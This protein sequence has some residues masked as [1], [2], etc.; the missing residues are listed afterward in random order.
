M[1]RVL[2][3]LLGL[4]LW[5][6]SAWA[7]IPNTVGWHALANT[8]IDSVCDHAPCDGITT[9]WNSA[10]YDTS[11]NRLVLMNNGGHGDYNGNEIIAIDLDTEAI[12][13]VRAASTVSYSGNCTLSDGTPR[14]FHTYTNVIYLPDQDQYLSLGGARAPDGFM[15][16][17]VWKYTPSSNTYTFL[18]NSPIDRSGGHWGSSVAWDGERHLV[19]AADLFNVFY[20]DPATSTWTTPSQPGIGDPDGSDGDMSGVVDPVRD[21]YYQIGNGRLRYWD[22]KTTSTYTRVN[23][24]LT[25]CTGA[26]NGAPGVAYDPTQDRIVIWNGGNTVYTL[27]PATHTCSSQSVSGGPTATANGTYGRFQ[28]SAKYHVFITCQ[29]VSANCYALRLTVQSADTDYARRCNAPGVVKCQ[30]F[31][32]LAD[33]THGQKYF[34]GDGSFD[35]ADLDT[36]TKVSGTGALRFNLPAGRATSDISGSWLDTLIDSSRSALT[37]FGAGQHWYYQW[38][39]RI[40]PS[41]VSNLSQWQSGTNTGWKTAILHNATSGTCS[42]I[43]LTQT[44]W[45]DSN[46]GAQI[47]YS[48]CG[49]RG[50]YMDAGGAQNGAGPYIQ[51]GSNVASKTDGYWCDFNS[52]TAGAGTG[53]GCFLWQHGDEWVTFYGHVYINNF[54]T[55]SSTW[56]VWI[57]RDGA[58]SY[59]QLMDMDGVYRFV[60][61]GAVNTFNRVTFTPYMTG[62]SS[63]ASSDANLWIDE[64]IVSTEPIDV[65]GQTVGGG[66]SP[67]APRN[68]RGQVRVSGIVRF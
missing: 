24:T 5:T 31:D 1:M 39:A 62:L 12:S 13:L 18:A 23:P 64:F 21:R 61:D 4:L 47:F 25:S 65:P 58:T 2:G 6:T 30:S 10:L 55:S 33:Y 37:G 48:E 59:T 19:W 66:S 15:Q 60:V 7:A 17:C 50:A 68:F 44:T 67:A 11:R 34:N 40:T 32:T 29:S 16:S 38:R 20:F 46:T 14:S 43:E 8:R 41:M 9:A 3:F 53:T 26:F 45:I 57:A 27:N 63:S 56:Q 28:Y 35:G 42:N 49:N 52:Q 51:Q 36:T 22:I 54:T